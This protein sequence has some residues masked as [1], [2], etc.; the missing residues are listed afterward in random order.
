M[1]SIGDVA[2]AVG[3]AGMW[4]DA[5]GRQH[6]VPDEAL[7]AILH[8]LGYTADSGADRAR[9]L[10]R[11]AEERAALPALI[12]GDAGLPVTLPAMVSGARQG[13]LIA[14]DG[15]VAPQ[16]LPIT[17]GVL[18]PISVP[19]YYRLRV[20]GQ[21]LRLAIA[22][23][24]C[25]PLPSAR[26]WGPAVQIPALRDRAQQGFGHLGN[27]AHAVH[28]FA[29]RGADALAI[30]PVHA[31]WPGDGSRYSPYAPSSRL[32]R[33][34]MLADP[35]LAGLPGYAQED[36]PDLIDWAEALP[37]RLATLRAA[38]ANID[39]TARARMH[40][41]VE[42]QGEAL[43]RHAL[44][45]ALYL[46]FA[47]TAGCWQD[48][49]AEYHDPAGEAAQ[50]FAAQHRGELSFHLFAQW[51]MAQNLEAVAAAGQ[52]MAIGL[53]ADLAVGIDPGGSDAWAMQ[54]LMLSGLSIGAPPDPLGPDGQNWG[55][56]SF[57]P[58]G[59]RASGFEPWIA[60]MR[61]ALSHAGGLRVDHAFGLQRL[62]VVPQGGGAKEGAYLAYPRDDLL[63]LAA[64]ESHRAGAVVI[65]EDLGTR[66]PGF[67]EAIKARG[68]A[69]MRVLWFERELDGAPIPPGRYDPDS[70]AMTGTHDTPTVA[71][72]WQ[73][74][75]MD[76]NDRLGRS[77]P[78]R[79]EREADRARLWSV[80]GDG[81][82]QPADDP[83]IVVD[84]ALRHVAAT[85]SRLAIVPLEDVLGEVE[86][87]NLPGTVDGHPNWRRRLSAPLDTLLA[88]P[89][90]AARI[91]ILDEVRKA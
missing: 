86:Q 65:A 81:A 41:W 42:G 53:I 17:D 37:L 79:S 69:G 4:Q 91:H 22:P 31:L 64:L 60:M 11:I 23:K 35:A 72:W 76:W 15:D 5:E 88:D 39:A 63:R 71:G 20:G 32:F 19:G 10:D 7:A 34:A 43:M 50:R 66:P 2:L 70:V 85:E 33:N 27:L 61:A 55:L 75:D 9:S 40:L 48:W 44:H 28:V 25:V 1:T 6:A 46:H 45:D 3:L 87:P 47:G 90:T 36:A 77:G 67:A 21:E 49:P 16:A 13:E 24:S 59:L 52:G 30:S 58:Q 73:G 12:T 8:A 62:W 80:L 26:C 83:A 84:A 51:L 54:P 56:T 29:E 38:F 57:S 89:A 78:A 18:S 74:R 82:P 14:E 68:M